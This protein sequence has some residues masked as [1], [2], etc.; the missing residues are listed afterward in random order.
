MPELSPGLTLTWQIAA[1]EA[2]YARHQCM[3][4]EHIFIALCKVTD[5]LSPE[6]MEHVEGL[7]KERLRTEL[8]K[9]VELFFEFNIDRKM[10]RR[11]LRE[12]HGKGNHEHTEDVVHRSEDCKKYFE[13][14]LDLAHDYKSSEANVF[15]LLVAIME[16]PGPHIS[17]ALSDFGIKAQDIKNAANNCLKEKPA[18][19]VHAG[20]RNNIEQ[21][22]QK[23]KGNT[24]FL[25]KYGKDLTKLAQEG[26][27]KQIFERREETL[28]VIRTLAR[29]N[30]NNP[31]LIGEPGVGKTAIVEGLALR[32]ARG[33]LT[34]LL[35]NKRIIEL[36][37]GSLVGG[38]KYRGEFEEKF[39]KII[40]EA[41]SN[42]D[43]ILF[44]D[45]IHTLIGAGSAEG[46]AMDAADILKPALG[47]SEITCIGATTISE[48]RKYIEKDPALERRFQPIVI[49]EPSSEETIKILTTL[50][51]SRKEV[52]IEASAI[53]AAVDL[54]VRYIL[55]KR[56][57]DK[58]IDILEAACSKVLVP[59]IT[60]HGDGTEMSAGFVTA[61]IIAEVVS[62]KTGIPSDRLKAKDKERFFKM[63]DVIKNRVIGQDEAVEKVAEVVKMQMAGLKNAGR[64]IGVFLFLGPTGVGKTELAKAAAEF[65][66]GS[67]N[68]IIRF[69]MSEFMEKH[70]VSRLIGAPPG[71]IGHDEEGQ[72]TGRLRSKPHCLVLL[73]EIE[74]AHPDIFDLFL[75]VFD[76]GRLT[77]SKGRAI[78]AT[79]ALF[80]MTSNVG[81]K[82]Y[83]KEPIG[84][85]HPESEEGKAIKEDIYS[86]LRQTFREEFL[87]RIDEIVF[88]KPLNQDDIIRISLNMLDEL[89]KKLEDKGIG[90]KIEEKAL[91]LI[92]KEGYDPANGARPLR[93]AIEKLIVKPLS[94]KLLM[95][96]FI[97]EDLII[98]DAEDGR[99]V[100]SKGRQ[101]LEKKEEWL[102]T[103]ETADYETISRAL[104]EENINEVIKNSEEV[105]IMFTDL[106]DCGNYFKEM[107]TMLAM[108]WLE[109]HYDILTTVIKSHGGD[110]VKIICDAIMAI[111]RDPYESVKAAA[112]MQTAISNHNKKAGKEEQYHIR[113]S[114]NS[115][116]IT[117]GQRGELFGRAINIAARIDKKLTSPDQILIG[118]NL[119]KAT[120]NDSNIKTNFFRDVEFK[121][122]HEKVK[123]YEVLWKEM[124]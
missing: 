87:N 93:R 75:Q 85:I 113:V 117:V 38:T 124:E 32:I 112:G 8:E 1:N 57:P 35:R 90:L 36:N 4:K 104:G 101:L 94:E 47:R 72:L 80:I 91:E 63:A 95:D 54:S 77:D 89:Q 50:Y 11:K 18:E 10:L 17:K 105:V 28:Q 48:Y 88:F 81:T 34:P 15:H 59:A 96:E 79:N 116:R 44:F 19:P 118:E 37:M 53:K 61:G 26:Q 42:K 115:G 119:Y 30:K 86:Q 22:D 83:Y 78:D 70:S 20:N 68:E 21:P 45:E 69:D 67:E 120:K 107:G 39:T 5:A 40:N 92:C 123:I 12:I 103:M 33:N 41:S 25:N 109:K 2:A 13:R 64:P 114:M 9:L 55:E 6:F 110:V 56:L 100:F 76:E 24:P 46:V 98:V 29:Q 16:N 51:E 52:H 99:I 43:I 27:L 65:L 108:E 66:F 84:F 62:E 74:K 97:E 111:F 102:H 23:S 7:N 31:V 49:K 3:E 14:A 121:E 58:A 82:S 106:K 71:Y 122:L 60:M 73:D